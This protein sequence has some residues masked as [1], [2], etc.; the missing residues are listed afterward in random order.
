HPLLLSAGECD[1]F[2]A[3]QRVIAIREGKYHIVD[4]GRFCGA[5]HFFL[6]DIAS[7]TIS[8]VLTDRAAEQEGLLLHDADLP[9]QICT[10]VILE[11]HA[12]QQYSSISVFMESRQEIYERGFA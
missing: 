8:N 2:L 10:R 11:L 1:A 12:V 7:Y 3:N 9:S 4:C 6:R 5:F